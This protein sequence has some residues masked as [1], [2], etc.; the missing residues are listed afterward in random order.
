MSVTRTTNSK[1]CCTGD[2]S[3]YINIRVQLF[4]VTCHDG[5]FSGSYLTN[6]KYRSMNLKNKWRCHVSSTESIPVSCSYTVH[7]GQNILIF[8]CISSW[9]ENFAKFTGHIVNVLRYYPI[10]CYPALFRFVEKI[11]SQRFFSCRCLK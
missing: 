10:P 6:Q 3:S 8:Q 9:N 2:E 4:Q 5:S 11:V 7:H 1:K